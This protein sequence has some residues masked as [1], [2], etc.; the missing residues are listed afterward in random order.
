MP[1]QTFRPSSV[2]RLYGYDDILLKDFIE[3]CSTG[4]LTPLVISGAPSPEEISDAWEK[5]VE[6][7]SEYNGDNQYSAHQ[8]LLK[9][10]AEL[11][12]EFTIVETSLTIL[13]YKVDWSIINDLRER[14]YDVATTAG[15]Y[16]T[17]SEA[18]SRSIIKL[19]S[20]IGHLRTRA[21]KRRKEIERRFGSKEKDKR[22]TIHEC[23]GSLELALGWTVGD[24]EKM[25]LS[26]YN[27]L[28]KGAN[29]KNKA[30]EAASKPQPQAN[31]SN[32]RR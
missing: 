27:I 15:N 25:T 32:R 31:G 26:R 17:I 14:G 5:I 13:W 1:S 11:E 8:Q 10:A 6:L 21:E 22:T 30:Q 9:S 29:D 4:S 24:A 18:Y 28:K 20:K 12:A 3:I 7:N 19:R 23:I 2:V 16:P